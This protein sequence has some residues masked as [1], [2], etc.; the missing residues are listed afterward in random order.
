MITKNYLNKSR[1]EQIN[2]AVCGHFKLTPAEFYSKNR[3]ARLV[4]PRFIAFRLLYDAGEPSWAIATEFGK[5][6]HASVL[7]GIKRI[8]GLASVDHKV[9]YAV[10][11][12]RE[13]LLQDLKDQIKKPVDRNQQASRVSK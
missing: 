12:I 7:H 1:A 6:S 8:D 3:A 13:R 4:I 5:E 9:A 2:A 10:R 11:T